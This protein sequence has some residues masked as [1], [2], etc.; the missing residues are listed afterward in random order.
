MFAVICDAAGGKPEA[1]IPKQA[2]KETM[3]PKMLF[4]IKNQNLYIW[5]KI[6]PL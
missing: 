2:R 5:L 4:V 3:G 1:P 6:W